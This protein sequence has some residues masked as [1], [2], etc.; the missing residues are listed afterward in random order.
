MKVYGILINILDKIR[1]G[2]PGGQ[3]SNYNPNPSDSEKVIY[4]RSRALIHLFLKAN[5]GLLDFIEREKICD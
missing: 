2:A 3:L 4:A 1:A 5:F